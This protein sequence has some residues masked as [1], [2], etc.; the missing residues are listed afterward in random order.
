MKSI[1]AKSMKGGL[2]SS[3]G[4]AAAPQPEGQ[5]SGVLP[6]SPFAGRVWRRGPVSAQ[7]SRRL[8]KLGFHWQIVGETFPRIHPGKEH[9]LLPDV[10]SERFSTGGTQ[11]HRNTWS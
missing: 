10:L 3:V 6:Q 11:A 7:V 5:T 2:F 1:A 8:K 9:G 4:G